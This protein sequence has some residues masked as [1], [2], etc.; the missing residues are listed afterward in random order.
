MA[1]RIPDDPVAHWLS[2]GGQWVYITVGLSFLVVAALTL[3]FAWI[4]FFNGLSRG[5]LPAIVT[6]TNDILLILIILEVLETILNYLQSHVILLEP[7]LYI[8]VIAAVRRILASGAY[9]T[10]LEGP[11]DKDIFYAYLWDLGMNTLVIVVLV[12]SI[13]LFSRRGRTA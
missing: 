2:R 7:F 12:F 8:G 9:L 5:V 3:V 4:N 13:F 10:I 1:T 11:I 6:L